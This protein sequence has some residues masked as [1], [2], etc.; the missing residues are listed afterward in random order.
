MKIL[1]FIFFLLFLITFFFYKHKKKVNE[2]KQENLLSQPIREEIES[3]PLFDSQSHSPSNEI[4]LS[5]LIEY[6]NYFQKLK[7]AYTQY[8]N[9]DLNKIICRKILVDKTFTSNQKKEQQKYIW[10]QYYKP[11]NSE[12][13]IQQTVILLHGL[14]INT[15]AFAYLIPFLI[16]NNIE[17][18]AFDLP[19][20]GLSYGSGKFGDIQN[21]HEY[22]YA[23][24]SVFQ[25]VKKYSKNKI[26]LISHSTG[27]TGVLGFLNSLQDKKEIALNI[28]IAP[29]IK[30]RNNDMINFLSPILAP[31][32]RR[33]SSS[34]D[35]NIPNQEYK[36]FRKQDVLT[37]LTFSVNWAKKLYLWQKEFPSYQTNSVPTV[38]FQGTED[39]VVHWKYNLPA[40]E[41]K[42][43][44][45]KVIYLEKE[46]HSLPY[47]KKNVRR[48]LFQQILTLLKNNFP[49]S[50]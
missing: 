7:F 28:M 31:L 24:E 14:G 36:N 6:K 17:V 8:S 48:L 45:L 12:E 26:S 46:R 19:Y 16:K 15:S 39:R 20:H 29:L 43:S 13:K 38:I 37:P 30:H 21:F 47:D 33:L 11:E 35:S 3:L 23:L 22:F 49:K 41:K 40:I 5:Q 42:Y 1:V 25:H 50:N 4:F 44:N 2:Q 10:L 32:I 34:R 9:F 18:Y 27:G